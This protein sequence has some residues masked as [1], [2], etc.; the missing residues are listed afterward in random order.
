MTTDV[1]TSTAGDEVT[2]SDFDLDVQI[3]ESPSVPAAGPV[4]NP[5]DDGCGK[6]CESACVG[7]GC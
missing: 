2:D 7:T 3:V 6:T 4:P 1:E 5:T